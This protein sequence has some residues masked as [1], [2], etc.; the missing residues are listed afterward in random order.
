MEIFAIE[1]LYN[2]YIKFES[3]ERK[4]MKI[5]VS[6]LLSA[7][8]LLIDIAQGRKE[9]A[10]KVTYISV[11]IAKKLNICQNEV[12][13]IYFASF[14]HDI[15]IT[16]TDEAFY[17]SHMDIYMAK[18]HC[19]LGYEFVNKLPLDEEIPLFIKY[20]HEFYNG[21]GAF[22]YDHCI[23]PFASQII[24]L[25][26]QVDI[27][28]DY[29]LPYYV[30]V[31]NIKEWVKKN[32]AI[33]F[34][35]IIAD[36]FL[37]IAE[38]DRFW[39]DIYNPQLRNIVLEL[40]PQDEVYFDIENMLKFSEA[41]ALIIDNKSK[42]THLHSKSLSE[43]VYSIAKILG[44]DDET[45]NKLKIA[46]YL[47]DIGKMVIPN[48]ILD[49]EGKLTTEEFYVIKSHPYYTKLI[50]DQIPVFKG[51]ISNWAGNHHERVNG[52]GYPEKLGKDELTLL[53]RVVG[54]CDVYQ[55]LIEDRPYRKG[56]SQKETLNIISDMVKN[57][58]FL[59]EEYMLLKK[60]V[61]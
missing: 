42:F 20:H 52:S 17:T 36:A 41:V 48:E 5:S 44:L 1:L 46:G 57:G 16:V 24:N 25:A 3:G 8:S 9:H 23:V 22:G 32:R 19:L 43:M 56:L 14:L 61:V 54:I 55:A 28:M 39:L 51:E 59:E 34:N 4:I 6:H 45:S 12:K 49:K 37:E 11:Q 58:L 35:P 33:L 40:S 29:T 53:D 7:I 30:Q 27:S 60:A 2:F 31:G 38:K 26:D 18:N 15:G 13:K 21:S 47:H 10:P 50:L